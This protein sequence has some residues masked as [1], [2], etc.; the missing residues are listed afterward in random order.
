M[1]AFGTRGASGSIAVTGR[2]LRA[3]MSGARARGDR[4]GSARTGGASNFGWPCFEGTA[5]R[6]TRVATLL[7]RDRALARIPRATARTARSSAVSS[8]RGR[9]H[10]G[11]GRPLPL[12]RPLHRQDDDRRLVTNGIAIRRAATSGSQVPELTS[13]GVD[14]LDR[15]Y[16]T[17]LRAACTG[18]IRGRAAPSTRAQLRGPGRRPEP[19]PDRRQQR[20]RRRRSPANMRNHHSAS[21]RLGIQPFSRRSPRCR[22]EAAGTGCAAAAPRSAVRARRPLARRSRPRGATVAPLDEPDDPH[23]GLLDGEL[24]HVDDRGSAA[25]GAASSASSS[26]SVHGLELGVALAWPHPCSSR[27]PCGCPRAARRRS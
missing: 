14:G 16:V 20:R 3:A 6:S 9:A 1:T 24:R 13:F 4:P 21:Q 2:P 17:S 19:E 10:P 25:C 11:A 8:S 23:R 18:S 27:A 7:G 12:R 5:R 26:S 15:I 22:P